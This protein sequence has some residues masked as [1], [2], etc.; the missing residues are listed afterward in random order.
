MIGKDGFFDWAT[1][2]PGHPEKV[3]PERNKEEGIAWHSAEGWLPS[4]RQL[5]KAWERKA[6]WTGSIS[7]HGDLFQ[8]Y[9][10]W[11]SCWASSSSGANIRTWSFE[12]EGLAGDLPTPN[13][14]RTIWRITAERELRTGREATRDLPGRNMWNHWELAHKYGAP[15]TSCPSGRY[16][17]FYA[18]LEARPKEDEMTPEEK[19]R[20]ERVEKILA[21][22]GIAQIAPDGSIVRKPDGKP[23]LTFGEDAL[24]LL[25]RNG[26]SSWLQLQ[27]LNEALRGL[28]DSVEAGGNELG[29]RQNA[30]ATELQALR[31]LF[32]TH[33]EDLSSGDVP[34]HTHPAQ[35]LPN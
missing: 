34:K 30:T 27:L 5:V 24:G 28:A 20:L 2:D 21:G 11:A 19:A 6:S 1:R 15:P 12:L 14:M 18:E 9:P 16:D 26:N 17:K 4:L 22:N 10:V 31:S 8:H 35:V 23:L 13:Q 33:V 25:A 32:I 7:L 29:A 3:Y